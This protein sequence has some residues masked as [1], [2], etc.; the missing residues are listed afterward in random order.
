MNEQDSQ[1]MEACIHEIAEILYRNT[2]TKEL[3]NFEQVE[4]AV[5]TRMLK[6]VSPKV[7]FFIKQVMGIEKGRERV[8]KGMVGRANYCRSAS[9]ELVLKLYSQVSPLLEKTVYYWAGMNHFKL[10]NKTSKH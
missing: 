8:V 10:R 3:I 2:V 4:R 6:E 7:A 5:R 9:K 1:R